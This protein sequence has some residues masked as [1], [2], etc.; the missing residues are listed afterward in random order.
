V[1]RKG[2][3]HIEHQYRTRF[4]RE[5]LRDWQRPIIPY[6][7]GRFFR[8]TL[9]RHFVLRSY[10][11]S[12]TKYILRAEASIRL[13]LMGWNPMGSLPNFVN[14]SRSCFLAAPL[15]VDPIQKFNKPLTIDPDGNFL[16]LW[17]TGGEFLISATENR[18]DVYPN[19]TFN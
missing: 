19:F 8:G 18:F 15:V 6:P 12:G 17:I 4:R 13:A 2:D 3:R 9:P 5:D 16:I 1:F 7:T 10:C 14:S 11:P